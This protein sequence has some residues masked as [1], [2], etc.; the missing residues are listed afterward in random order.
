MRLNALILAVPLVSAQV[1]VVPQQ[2]IFMGG[3]AVRTQGCAAGQ[4]DCGPSAQ[5]FHSCCPTGQF[6]RNP[7]GIKGFE[8]NTGCCPTA[9]DCSLDL[10]R[11]YI[12]ANDAWGLYNNSGFPFCCQTGDKGGTDVNGTYDSCRQIASTF[13]SGEVALPQDAPDSRTKTLLVTTTYSTSGPTSPP[14]S[15]SAGQAAPDSNGMNCT[16]LAPAAIAGIIVGSI[17]AAMALALFM[18][19]LGR[20]SGRNY[21]RE[22]EE[23]LR[24][25]GGIN[26]N[27][28]I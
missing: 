16:N 18:W 2:E 20:R 12:C 8:Q 14:T 21:S 13:P 3:W 15:T 17:V 25:V 9:A 4:Q 22:K 11:F 26:S 19:Y 27:S 28:P 23:L 7:V 1:S 10:A 6:C 5:G 24:Q